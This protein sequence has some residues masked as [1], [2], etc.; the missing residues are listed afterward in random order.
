[1]GLKTS[2]LADFINDSVKSSAWRRKRNL[3]S[4]GSNHGPFRMGRRDIPQLL[5]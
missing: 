3:C 4:S 1:V 5:Q 2:D